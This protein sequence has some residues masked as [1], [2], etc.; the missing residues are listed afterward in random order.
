MGE[1]GG[2]CKHAVATGLAWLSREEK[3]GDDLA[4]VRKHLE[5]EGKE[6]LVE[7]LLDQAANDPE[8][9][10]R[11][12]AESMRRGPHAGAKALKETVRKAF[13]VRGFVDWQGMPTLVTRADGVADLLRGLLK[14]GRAP[15]AVDMA[16]YAMRRGIAAYERSDDSSGGF[17]QTLHQIAALH[18]QACRAAKPDP[19]SLAKDLFGLHML[20]QWDFF[21][22]ADYEPLLEA[23][24]LARYRALAEAEWKKVPARAPGAEREFD[25]DRTLI[26]SIMESLAEHD[27]NADALVAVK[28][29]DLSHAHAFVEIAEILAREGRHAEALGW[30]ERGRKAF[31]NE[32]NVPLVDFLVAAYHRAGRHEDAVAAAWDDFAGHPGLGAYA[33]LEASARRAK[34]WPARREKALAHVRAQL[35]RRDRPRSEW[36]WTSGGRTLLVEIFLHEGDSDAALAE[37]SAGGCRW[38]AWMKLAKA[39]EKDHPSDAAAVYRE[40]IEAATGTTAVMVARRRGR[41]GRLAGLEYRVLRVPHAY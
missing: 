1:E 31:P 22:F 16:G 21:E 38:D 30:A 3:G 6:A 40:R 29:R 11:L 35:A 10:A 8:L 19:E 34:S 28:S 41:A 39:R 37:A 20:D 32:L 18:L 12:E 36:H 15:E 24:G 25:T 2:F 14:G 27:G 23:K 4:G 26:T 9:R 13:A 33:R 5:A 7:L 17:G